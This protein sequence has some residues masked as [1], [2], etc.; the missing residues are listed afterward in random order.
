MRLLDKESLR[1]DM[2]KLGMEQESLEKFTTRHLQAVRHGAGH[3]P[4]G[5]R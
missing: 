1:L 5:F 3:R 4:H 2:T